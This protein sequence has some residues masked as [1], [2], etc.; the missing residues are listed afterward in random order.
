[1]SVT[2]AM[3]SETRDDDIGTENSSKSMISAA[4]SHPL[5]DFRL[6]VA[7]GAVLLILGLMMVISSSS[8]I[9]AADMG[10]PYYFGKR[11]ILFALIGLAGAWMLSMVGEN[12]V[13]GLSWPALLLA[14]V[15]IVLTFTPL[16]V[17]VSG[18]RN[19]L[20]FGPAWAQFQPSEFAKLAIIVWGANDLSRRQKVLGDMRQ[21]LVYIVATFTIIALVVLQQD[22]GTA[23]VLSA[24]VILVLLAA[25]APWRLLAGLA[26]GATA[27]VVALIIAQP[28]RMRRIWAFFNPDADPLG[29][30]LQARRGIYAFASGGWFGQGLG[31]SRQKWGLLAE[32]HTDYIFAI[33]GEELGLIGTLTVI[34]LFV[35][36]AYVGVRTAI[37]SDSNFSR[38]VAV[39]VVAWFTVQAFVNMA[40]ALRLVPVMG[41]TLPMIS[42][43]GSSLMAN[44]FALGLLAGCARREPKARQLFLGRRHKPRVHAIV[45]AGL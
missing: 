27:A 32:P 24:I 28:Y 14:I 36:L 42:Y 4:F 11:Q 6:V 34:A 15:L 33:I 45:R 19:W 10:D 22:Q 39:G 41:V 20:S 37:R 3:I 31:A 17:T 21:W 29:L 35:I 8:V 43:G 2:E 40:V 16:G 18:N 44:L 1:M 23:M 26:G 5:F 25:G 13:K 30:N 12:V 7:T 38:L 9:A